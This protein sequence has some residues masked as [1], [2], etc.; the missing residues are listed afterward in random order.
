M[1]VS[2]KGLLLKVGKFELDTLA[3]FVRSCW[4]RDSVIAKGS[5]LRGIMRGVDWPEEDPD[6]RNTSGESV[7][8]L[9]VRN[10][11]AGSGWL[12]KCEYS[13]S[14]EFPEVVN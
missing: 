5:S 4:S 12:E 8:K 11:S 7:F 1:G 10:E 3:G 13:S 2:V 6:E 9:N 14:D